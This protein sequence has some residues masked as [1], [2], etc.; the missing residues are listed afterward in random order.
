MDINIID[1]FI[2]AK[3]KTNIDDENSQNEKNLK[4][5]TSVISSISKKINNMTIKED[6]EKKDINDTDKNLE[7]TYDK[8][9]GETYDKEIEETY[10]KEIEETYDKEIEETYDKLHKIMKYLKNKKSIDKYDIKKLNFI[11]TG[12][13]ILDKYQKVS[14]DI[15]EPLAIDKNDIYDNK[16]LQQKI[17][18]YLD[19]YIEQKKTIIFDIHNTVEYDG[20]IDKD[21]LSFININKE[22]INI[23]LLSYDGN[24]ERIKN[25]NDLLNKL[26]PIFNNIP[27]IFIKKRK[28]HYVI[29]NIL[30]II[31][32]NNLLFVDD[33]INNIT[34]SQ[35]I[36][37]KN[38]KIFH[39]TAHTKEKYNVG[40]KNIKEELDI[41]I[42]EK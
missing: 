8:E 17:K 1:G 10:D 22:K 16:I 9:I 38:L 15:I 37:N 4:S 29:N 33:N 6:I 13:N 2:E 28:K 5:E 19:H 34:D 39:Y 41:F 35:K 31:G 7:E 18:K 20:Q 24:D 21:I 32:N 12:L 14:N 26:S 25:N 30:K 23:I 11:L 36:K 27:K 40:S 3:N 42:S